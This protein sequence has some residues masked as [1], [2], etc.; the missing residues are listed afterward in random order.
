MPEV[1]GVGAF[2]DCLV[3]SLLDTFHRI[4]RNRANDGGRGG[5]GWRW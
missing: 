5:A 3:D 4:E 1:Y 2:I